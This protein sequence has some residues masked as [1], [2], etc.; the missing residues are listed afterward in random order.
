MID[1]TEFGRV[2]G[3]IVRDATE[4]LKR[5]IEALKSEVDMLRAN[6]PGDRGP[7]PTQEQID[8]AVASYLAANPAK[9]EKGGPGN[10]PSDSR[11]ADAV[12]S[13]LK[14]NP[15][16]PGEKGDSGAP[17]KDAEIDMADVCRELLATPEIKTLVDLHAAAAVDAYFETNPVKHGVDGKPGRDGEHGK[18]GQPGARGEKGDQGPEGLGLKDLF[19]AEGGRLMAVLSNGETR[20]L[21]EFVGKDGAPGKDGKD[22]ISFEAVE[23]GYDAEMHEIECRWLDHGARKSM[24]YPA[25]GIRQ[26]GYWKQGVEAK[27]GDT[28][29][30]NGNA[31]VAMRDTKSEPAIHREDDW[32]ILARKGRDGER[33]PKGMDAG[34]PPPVKLQ[35]RT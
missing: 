25:G 10:S 1:A 23:F 18:D 20:D 15:P 14:A 8:A 31:W 33:G 29:T 30:H 3:G 19:R 17:G 22:G 7:A 13:Y 12:S 34:P 27:A 11:I 5:Q 32:T 2:M 9:G 4:P 24:R 28:Y 26:R 35:D 16:S 6:K 21:G